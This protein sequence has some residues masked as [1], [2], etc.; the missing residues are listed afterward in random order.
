M[1]YALPVERWLERHCW[2]TNA[3][4]REP[5]TVERSAIWYRSSG[6]GWA[7]CLVVRATSR[8]AVGFK[9][10][11]LHLGFTGRHFVGCLDCF[12]DTQ[13]G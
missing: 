10:L 4:A 3:F 1:D 9:K 8:C 6:L 7:H 13:F 12:G 5:R 11:T 2:S